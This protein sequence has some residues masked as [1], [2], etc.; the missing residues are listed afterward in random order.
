[1][2]QLEA[3]EVWWFSKA[4]TTGII[5]RHQ[6]ERKQSTYS[7]C[8]PPHHC[9]LNSHHLHHKS[10]W[11]V[12]SA[13]SCTETHHFCTAG[14][15]LDLQSLQEKKNWIVEKELQGKY[16]QSQCRGDV[17]SEINTTNKATDC[18]LNL[19]YYTQATFLN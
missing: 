7:I 5:H 11:L 8:G 18:F 14:A 13:S 12:C 9:H 3:T 15:P 2:T 19:Y 1:M 6:R 4:D 16:S 10:N 17:E